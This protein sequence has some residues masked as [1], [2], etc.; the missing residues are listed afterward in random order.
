MNQ[1]QFKRDF[2][3]VLTVLAKLIEMRDS[4]QEKV[5]Y[6]EVKK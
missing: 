3:E 6:K 5:K 2:L 1:Q 4:E